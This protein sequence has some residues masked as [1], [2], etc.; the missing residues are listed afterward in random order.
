MKIDSRVLYSKLG[1][2]K[3][4]YKSKDTKYKIRYRKTTV[5]SKLYNNHIFPKKTTHRLKDML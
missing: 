5:I 3:K 2:I 4:K 1:I